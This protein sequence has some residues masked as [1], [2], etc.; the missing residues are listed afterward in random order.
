MYGSGYIRPLETRI[1]ISEDVQSTS[2]C[3]KVMRKL[4]YCYF[5]NMFPPRFPLAESDFYIDFTTNPRKFYI[6]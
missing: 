1:D 5:Y 3:G 2:T 4:E 6:L